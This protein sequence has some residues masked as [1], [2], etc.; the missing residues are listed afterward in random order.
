MAL[1]QHRMSGPDQEGNRTTGACYAQATDGWLTVPIG[2]AAQAFRSVPFTRTVLVVGR[3]LHTTEW[4]LD[5]LP[6]VLGDRRIQVVFTVEDAEP[7]AFHR[8]AHDVLQLVGAPVMP[9]SQAVGSRFDLIVSSSYNGTLHALSGP[10]LLLPHGP[11]FGKPASLP[12]AG[13]APTPRDA[14][15]L[16]ERGIPPTT[17]VISHEEQLHLFAPAPGIRVAVVGDPA[18]DR[19]CASEGSRADYRAALG[20]RPHQALIVLSST[21]GTSSQFARLPD[22]PLRLAAEL[23][24]DDYRI[25]MIVHPNVWSGHGPWQ[26]RSWLRTAMAAG[27]ILTRPEGDAWRG[28]LVASDALVA[29]HGSVALYG[30]ALGRP[31]VL[32]GFA[33]DQLIG[34]SPLASVGR[35]APRLDL[36]SPLRAQLDAV[37]DGDRCDELRDA[38]HQTFGLPGR[39]LQVL[40]AIAYEILGLDPPRVPPRVRA[41]GMPA[42]E[43]EPVT[44]HHVIVTADRPGTFAITRVPALAEIAGKAA[45][46]EAAPARHSHWH[47][48]VEASEPDAGIRHSATVIWRRSDGAAAQDDGWAMRTLTENPGCEVAADVAPTRATVVMRGAGSFAVAAGSADHDTFDAAV[49]PSAFYAAHVLSTTSGHVTLRNGAPAVPLTVVPLPPAP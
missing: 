14:A 13:V 34:T 12:R 2:E 47:L 3:T 44:A 4:M 23:P 25:A 16:I 18:Y 28:V 48:A 1:D 19:L 15:E 31:I 29:D 41:V 26:L 30:A 9:W 42:V 11:G 33:D 45:A 7:S 40:R 27:V 20:L 38:V 21:W 8:S 32:A 43:R 10:L 39:S 37:M 46:A 6:E 35:R 36:S 5:L 17:V 49:L 24:W 22:L